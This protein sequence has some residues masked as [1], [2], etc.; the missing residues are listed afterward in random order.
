MVFLIGAV[1]GQTTPEPLTT[2]MV[3]KNYQT[4]LGDTCC[5]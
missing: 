5:R 1:V 4:V 3:S 2:I